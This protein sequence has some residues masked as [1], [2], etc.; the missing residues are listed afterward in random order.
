MNGYLNAG[1]STVNFGKKE[2][3]LVRKILLP[4]TTIVYLS[5]YGTGTTQTWHP[6]P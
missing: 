2:H 4:E 1:R 3:S 6:F 5:I